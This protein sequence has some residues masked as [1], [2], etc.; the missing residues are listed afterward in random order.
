MRPNLRMICLVTVEYFK[1][2]NILKSK[3]S[4]AYLVCL[5]YEGFCSYN[6]QAVGH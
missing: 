1:Y 2:P 5:E 3:F 6:S 4:Y